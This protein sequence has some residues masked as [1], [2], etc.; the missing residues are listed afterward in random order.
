MNIRRVAPES[1]RARRDG[2]RPAEWRWARGTGGCSEADSRP[3]RK[4]RRTA[5]ASSRPASEFERRDRSRCAKAPSIGRDP[6]NAERRPGQQAEH[7][8]GNVAVAAPRVVL[9]RRE[10]IEILADEKLMQVPDALRTDHGDIPGHRH[11]RE[12]ER[13]P[14]RAEPDAHHRGPSRAFAIVQPT[15]NGSMT[16]A[17]RTTAIGPFVKDTECGRRR[18]RRRATDAGA[19]PS[20]P[21]RQR[22]SS[23]RATAS[24]AHQHATLT[25]NASGTSGSDCLAMGTTPKP[26]A[27]I[28]PASHAARSSIQRRVTK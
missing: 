16:A 14:R 15:T 26:V 24:I 22:T 1:G 3:T 4:I 20:G 5:R 19:D 28:A 18:P 8:H 23:R 27:T 7:D 21:S 25:K 2:L 17:G 6:Q 9:R 13:R 11:R 12:H 10:T